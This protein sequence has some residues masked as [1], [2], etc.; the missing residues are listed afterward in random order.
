MLSRAF[1]TSVLHV[2]ENPENDPV[3][4]F[5]VVSYEYKVFYVCLAKNIR[6]TVLQY[7][8]SAIFLSPVLSS[9]SHFIE[10]WW[11]RYVTSTKHT[12]QVLKLKS[13]LF[14]SF[15][16]SFVSLSSGIYSTQ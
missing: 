3:E 9:L 6:L 4:T 12:E 15:H 5:S 16:S 11:P 14:L 8:Q 10:L 1:K 13:Y 2:G 7:V